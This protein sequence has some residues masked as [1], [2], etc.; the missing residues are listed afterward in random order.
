MGYQL[1]NKVSLLIGLCIIILCSICTASA[2]VGDW[3][4]DGNKVYVDDSK[5]YL[6][7]EPHTLPESGFVY[8]D[9]NPK[10]YTGDV[11]LYFGFNSDGLKPTSA[12]YNNNGEWI[13]IASHFNKINYD[14]DVFDRWYY[15]NNLPVQADKTY[16][17]AVWM[18][19]SNT[20]SAGKYGF[21]IKPSFQTLDQAITAGNFY[22]L[23]PWWDSDFTSLSTV[24]LNASVPKNNFQVH[25]T[26][27]DF[28]IPDKM[29][30][31]MNTDGN[32]TRILHDND[33]TVFPIWIEHM[34][35]ADDYSIW[36]NVTDNTTGTTLKWYYGNATK[37]SVSDIENTMI[38]GDDFSGDTLDTIDRWNS[39]VAS[40][41]SIT[42]DD[43]EA[44]FTTISTSAAF[45][46]SAVLSQ[47]SYG[48]DTIL[49][50]KAR[51]SNTL[52]HEFRYSTIGYGPYEGPANIYLKSQTAIDDSV[53]FTDAASGNNDWYYRYYINGAEG[54]ILG[55]S[56]STTYKQ[57]M[58][59]RY[60]TNKA[61]WLIDSAQVRGETTTIADSTQIALGIDSGS[62]TPG[63][64][65]D[66]VVDH[67]F[68]RKYATVDPIISNIDLTVFVNS[69]PT[70]PINIYP[71][72]DT[73][74]RSFGIVELNVS[75]TDADGDPINYLFYGDTVDG[76]TLLGYSGVNNTTFA[77]DIY[78]YGEYYWS[79]VAYDGYNYSAY[80][81]VFKF[82]LLAPPNLTA[83]SNTSTVYIT[84]PPL[85]YNIDFSWQ[86]VAV[87]QYKL[88][89]AEDVN[90][91]VIAIN[92][93]VGINNSVQSLL[94]NKQY[95]WKV[96]SYDGTTYS[97][98]SA[99]YN[100]N[101]TGNS[102]LT[103]SAIEGV[104]YSDIDGTYA[105]LPGTEVSIWNET[106]TDTAI[107][108]SNGYY[109]FT[110][111][112]DGEVYNVHAKKDLYLDSSVALV[113]ATTDP[114]TQNF[115][116]LPDRTSEEWRH[117]V[118]FVVWGPAGYYEGVTVTVYENSDV[119]AL[120]TTE[121][122]NDGAA[123]FI[124]DRQQEYRVTFIDA[125]QGINREM[126]LFPKDEKY[127]IFV[128]STGTWTE[129]EDPQSE[130]IDI[131]VSTEEIN[132]THAYI[133]I[134][135]VDS[136][137][138]TSSW[139]LYLNQSNISTP[140][141]QDTLQ[142]ASDTTS[143]WTHSFVVSEY[144]GQSYWINVRGIHTTYGN[145]NEQFS[146]IFEDE[147][148][149]PGI[150][151]KVWLYV[152]ILVMMFTGGMF[153]ASTAP[154]GAMIIC[155]EGWVFLFFGWF[156][157]V[158]NNGIIAVGLG[159]ATVVSIIANINQYSKKEGHE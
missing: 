64:A 14:Y 38:F 72:D 102:T 108:G 116:L 53:L 143:N 58:I 91:N 32:D 61:V 95:W 29:W 100:F 3:V 16:T 127:L 87:Q 159:F 109:L 147:I 158:D 15:S 65:F 103:G 146:V 76:S 75:S 140:H 115:Y 25:L 96:Y 113:N 98:S 152:A 4:I 93:H 56:I 51:F 28:P 120:Y 13:N 81:D 45:R 33:V 88:M 41:C 134:S 97:N 133:N 35:T 19:Q 119:T 48:V 106:W 49:E 43:G 125:T 82:T 68:V 145:I 50:S 39:Y 86:D 67:V 71:V 77:W 111:V 55:E 154:Q 2:D 8:F 107:T 99:V 74:V 118:K 11:D 44:T 9:I 141:T 110:G 1:M 40:G 83:P 22:Y 27:A 144:K 42:L 148:G 84:Y 24:T 26:G 79:A 57:F 30:S 23:D 123:T 92:E 104:C 85:T 34:T 60:D 69:V 73:Y 157:S 6:S 137:A 117:Y 121:T 135:Y 112:A 131:E 129:H 126:V 70:V 59:K 105:A 20:I 46:Q 101:L 156:A 37:S 122:G 94:V 80:S 47:S 153:G 17:I 130:I 136:L 114:I 36:V 18:E 7:A 63:S 12:Y 139:T 132:S 21:A 142:S 10:T 89:V 90:F 66:M 124:M 128:A 138:E 5:V 31:N 151:A 155:V 52:N 150:P 149:I 62:G 78:Q 54:T